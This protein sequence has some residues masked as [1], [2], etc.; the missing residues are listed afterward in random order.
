MYH[1]DQPSFSTSDDVGWSDLML[2]G[3]TFST[4]N[5]DNETR[6]SIKHIMINYEL[7]NIYLDK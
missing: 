4:L 2:S 5:S 6:V 7:F 1:Y 3:V